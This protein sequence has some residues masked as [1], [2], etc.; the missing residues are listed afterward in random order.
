LDE[1]TN[2]LDMRSKDVLKEALKEFNGTAIIVSHDREFLDGLVDK[3][4]EFGNQ[5]VKEHIG[6]IYEFLEKKKI[7]TLRELERNTKPQQEKTDT[8]SAGLSKENPPRKS[9]GSLTYEERKEQQR[10]IKRL[11]KT[12]AD[13]ENQIEKIETEIK[14]MEEILATP[15]GA[16]N[17]DLLWKHAE[18]QKKISDIMN[19]W[20]DATMELEECKEK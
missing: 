20:T 12:V 16:S 7:E 18:M 14:Q 6:G 19:K 15:E 2:H 3:V 10:Q 17:V 8:Q 1:P 4:Y 11:E 5:R 13:L 9:E